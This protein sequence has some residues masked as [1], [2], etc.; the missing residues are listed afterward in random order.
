M[1]H[2]YYYLISI[3]KIIKIICFVS[4]IHSVSNLTSKYF[5]PFDDFE[6]RFINLKKIILV[7]RKL[8]VIAVSVDNILLIIVSKFLSCTEVYTVSCSEGIVFSVKNRD[9]FATSI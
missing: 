7:I 2:E 5:Q 1:V 4:K 3:V 9:I 8:T 6:S